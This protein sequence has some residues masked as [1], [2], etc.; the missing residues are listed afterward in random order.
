MHILEARQLVGGNV[1]PTVKILCG[2][3]VKETSLQKGT[4]NPF[5]NEV[6]VPNWIVLRVH[7]TALLVVYVNA[8]VSVGRVLVQ[9]I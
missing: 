9:S 2:N 8:Y 1:N 7:G 4:N 6:C 5:W 3:S